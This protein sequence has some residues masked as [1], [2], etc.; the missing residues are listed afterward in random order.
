MISFLEDFKPQQSLMMKEELRERERE[1]EVKENGV[2]V[3]HCFI[4]FIYL[5]VCEG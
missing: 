2:V 4:K 5:W 1:R 3:I